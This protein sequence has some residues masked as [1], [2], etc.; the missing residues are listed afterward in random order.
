[1][2]RAV[3][4]PN[5]GRKSNQMTVTQGPVTATASAPAPAP[6]PTQLANA[7]LPPEALAMLKTI[8][9]LQ[10]E[11]LK[12]ST[13]VGDRF[14][15]KARAIHYGEQD[16]IPI[17]GQATPEEASA[18]IEEGVEIAPILFPVSPPGKAN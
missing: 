12:S 2:I 1:M 16:A 5:L 6:A 15:D 8:A 4:A 18:L 10:A 14:A 3:S 7:P 13:W 9:K 11:A 17:H